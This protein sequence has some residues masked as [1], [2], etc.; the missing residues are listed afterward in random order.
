[1]T[2]GDPTK[3]VN[4]TNWPAEWPSGNTNVTNWPSNLN[5]NIT[6]WIDWTNYRPSGLNQSLGSANIVSSGDYWSPS[7][8][9]DGYLK[10]YLYIAYGGPATVAPN[11]EVWDKAGGIQ[12]NA[13]EWSNLANGVA[14]K[15][16]LDVKGPEI[17]V[18]VINQGSQTGHWLSISLG[19]YAIP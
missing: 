10:Y 16:P 5:V 6:N 8:A 3:F 15:G 12:L 1:M 19:I 17:Q 14:L 4:V 7:I 2:S 13:E 18:H 9:I 11:V